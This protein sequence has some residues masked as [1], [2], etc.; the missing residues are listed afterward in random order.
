MASQA[1]L[2]PAAIPLSPMRVTYNGVEL[3]GTSA[4]ELGFS[5][6][7][8]DIMVDQLGK[9]PIDSVISSQAYTVKFTIY[10]LENKD[11]WKVAFPYAKLVTSGPNKALVM[12][13][14]VGTHLY[15][16]A[17]ELILHPLSKDDIDLS[18]DYK[19]FKAVCVSAEGLKSSSEEQSGLELTFNVFPDANNNFFV[20]GDPT[21]ALTAASA[22]APV[23]GG[24]NVGNG[25]VT[26]VTLGSGIM[27]ETLTLTCIDEGANAGEFS[28]VGSVTGIKGI[29]TVGVPFISSYISFTINDGATDFAEGDTFTIALTAA[30]YV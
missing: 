28:V 14:K 9:T 2:N 12:D 3:G 5:A 8:A 25:T 24:G 1:T 17:E 29:A 23:A 22:G 13:A 20:H 11:N 18:G 7:K 10:E 21:I 27:T 6:E 16:L 19:F 4:I 30:N 15:A 26:S